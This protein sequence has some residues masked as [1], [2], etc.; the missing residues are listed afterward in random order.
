MLQY[1]LYAMPREDDGTEYDGP[2]YISV[3]YK[4]KLQLPKGSFLHARV[5]DVS[6]ADLVAITV[7]SARKSIEGY[8]PFSIKLDLDLV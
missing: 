7:T 1:W 2:L 4:E 8:P 3:T 5:E 6:K